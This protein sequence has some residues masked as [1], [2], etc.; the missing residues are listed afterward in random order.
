MQPDNH[1]D[2]RRFIRNVLSVCGVAL[3]L[4]AIVFFHEKLHF[5]GLLALVPVVGAVIVIA[6]GPHAWLNR[7]I[8][9]SVAIR[10]DR[11]DQLSALSVALA[12]A[13]AGPHH[14]G[15]NAV[16]HDACGFGAARMC[17]GC[18][19]LLAR[20]TAGTFRWQSQAARVLARI[21]IGNGRR[22][23]ADDILKRRTEISILRR[24]VRYDRPSEHRLGIPKE[25]G[26][27]D[28]RGRGGIL[29]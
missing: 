20:R 3:L 8:L 5:P 29:N 19:H 25:H 10:S 13:V 9:V 27:T 22:V 6:A 18:T 24:R 14:R 2:V 17:P 16:A 11:P 28:R 1:P 12:A 26:E 7:T 4:S 15:S 23:G 21:D